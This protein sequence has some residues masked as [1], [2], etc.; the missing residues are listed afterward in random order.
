MPVLTKAE[1]GIA[2]NHFTPIRIITADSNVTIPAN[3]RSEPKMIARI[4]GL[5]SL[6]N[7]PGA[8][9]YV[10]SVVV[11]VFDFDIREP[12]PVGEFLLW[13]LLDKEANE[14]S[15]SED[16]AGVIVKVILSVAPYDSINSVFNQSVGMRIKVSSISCK[17]D[18]MLSVELFNIPNRFVDV[19]VE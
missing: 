1:I 4:P 8:D 17:K 10:P 3:S 18:C 16:V 13:C 19:L 5:I 11:E 2:A 12:G 6:W 15:T 7:S 14:S 9:I